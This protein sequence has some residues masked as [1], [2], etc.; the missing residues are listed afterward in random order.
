MAGKNLD[1][2]TRTIDK[3]PDLN[4]KLGGKVLEFSLLLW[5]FQGR[6]IIDIVG[7]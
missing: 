2:A 7:T 6:Q 5:L 4:S 1:D 3:R